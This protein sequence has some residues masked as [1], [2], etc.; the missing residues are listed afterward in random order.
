MLKKVQA[1]CG[2]WN[3]SS[4][5]RIVFAGDEVTE[6][7]EKLGRTEEGD[8]IRL[9]HEDIQ[10]PLT[11][12][13]KDAA[14][15]ATLGILGSESLDCSCKYVLKVLGEYYHADRAYVLVPVEHGHILT[16]PYEW[17]AGYKNSIQQA[18]SGML[19]SNFPMILRCAKENRPIFLTREDH[20]EGEWNFAVFPM[21]YEGITHGYMCIENAKKK[22][23]D[24]A[25][26]ELL[27]DCLMKEKNRYLQGRIVQNGEAGVVGVDLPNLSSYMETVYNINSDIYSSLGAVS[28]DVPN[29]SALNSVQGFEFGR[30]LL[31]YVSQTMA[32][33]FGRT[34][35]YRTWDAEFVVFC[36]NTTGQVFYGK[37]A[38]LKAALDRRYPKEIRVGY[39]WSDKVFSGRALVDEAKAVMRCERPARSRKNEDDAC[40]PSEFAVCT[41][42]AEMVK[43]GMFTVFF[44]PK[45]D[46]GTGKIVGAEALVRG[47]DKEKNVIMPTKFIDRLENDGSIRNLDLYVLDRTMYFLSKWKSQGRSLVPVSVNFSRTTLLDARLL[48]SVLAIQS[49]YP[50]IESSLVQIEVKEKTWEECKDALLPV[51]ENLGQYGAGFGLDDFRTGKDMSTFTKAGF[52]TIKID[53]SLIS[54]IV[55]DDESLKL[56][57]ETVEACRTHGISCVAE[58]V[59]NMDQVVALS[60]I[61][62]SLAQGFYYDRPLPA[63]HFC[64]KYLSLSE[65]P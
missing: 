48:A 63:E 52:D 11:A 31:W 53:V 21:K 37:C 8:R 44:Q 32:D 5:D 15:T 6:G 20:G 9:S 19:T 38:R 18:V 62:C 42:I 30:R 39:T 64:K 35:L 36:P 34:F 25:L 55:T 12:Q 33:I 43:A 26:A 29:L 61:G 51:M 54:Q 27:C 45:V 56:A 41:S 60:K 7:C 28:V 22:I 16:M 3:N 23:T 57:A 46:I 50:D 1:L 4:V 58:G 17:T 13:E 65:K 49:H 59:E 10:R 40:L 47:I 14:L 24:A 2:L